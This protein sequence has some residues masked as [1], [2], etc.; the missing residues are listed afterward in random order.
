MDLITGKPQRMSWQKE[1]DEIN[2]RREIAQEL[3]GAAATAKRRELGLL[4]ARER[5]DKLLDPGSFRELG[6]LTGTASYDANFDLKGMLPAN[7]VIGTGK[8]EGRKVSI[9]ADDWTI[10]S[11][12]SITPGPAQ[13]L[14]LPMD[15]FALVTSQS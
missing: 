14:L 15:S 1:V 6:A 7:T 5:I 2:R 12:I 13:P 8:V 10:S 9:N 4:N 3:G 11:A